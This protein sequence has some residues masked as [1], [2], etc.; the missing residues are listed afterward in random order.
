MKLLKL[1]CPG[2]K[3]A[4]STRVLY[5]GLLWEVQVHPSSAKRGE[6]EPR[7]V[8]QFLQ[9]W[10]TPS[11]QEAADYSKETQGIYDSF[12]SQLK[13][14]KLKCISSKYFHFCL[15]LVYCFSA[16]F[17]PISVAKGQ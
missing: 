7:Y 10:G 14:N 17:F 3:L 12:Y 11:E 4:G 9:P 13:I 1:L 6:I 15:G 5:A 2:D 8:F 16:V